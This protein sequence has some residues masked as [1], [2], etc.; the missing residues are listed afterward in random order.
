MWGNNASTIYGNS[1]TVQPSAIQILIII[2]VWNALDCTVLLLPYR[3]LDL[4]ASIS[5]HAQVYWLPEYRPRSGLLRSSPVPTTQPPPLRRSS[6]IA[7]SEFKFCPMMFG[8][9]ATRTSS[10]RLE[11]VMLNILGVPAFFSLNQGRQQA[12]WLNTVILLPG[13]FQQTFNGKT[14]CLTI[15]ILFS[16]LLLRF[17]W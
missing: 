4:D 6:G 16:L 12:V 15:R 14:R 13:K 8:H 11:L 1:S 2:K 5:H 9:S 7:Y 10:G 3:P 17:W